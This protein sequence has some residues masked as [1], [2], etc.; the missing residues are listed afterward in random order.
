MHTVTCVRC[1]GS[2]F[3]LSY[4]QG[5]RC[6]ILCTLHTQTRTDTAYILFSP[7]DI[8]VSEMSRQHFLFVTLYVLFRLCWSLVEK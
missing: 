7:G 6:T 8:V 5:R 3:K 2:H 1:S 4:L